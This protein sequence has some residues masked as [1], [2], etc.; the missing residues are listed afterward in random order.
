MRKMGV[1][2]GACLAVAAGAAASTAVAQE[3]NG[4][5]QTFDIQQRFEYG[6]NVDLEV[7]AEGSTTAAATVLSY[8]L[9]SETALDRLAFTATGA[10]VIENSPDTAGTEVEFDRPE[11]GFLYVREIP[12]ALFSIS[13]RYARDDVSELAEDLADA[14]ADGTEID[15]GVT[16]RYEG[17][18]TSPASIF[19]EATFDGTEYEDTTD[20]TL[21]ESDTFGIAVGTRLRLNEVLDGVFSLGAEREE[22]VTGTV[23]NRLVFR[24]GLEYEMIDG[25]AAVFLIREDGDVEDSTGLE[26]DYTR[27]LA[28]GALSFGLS[29]AESDEVGV[30]G[31]TVDTDID[32]GWAQSVNDVSSITLAV[33]WAQSDTPAERI[34]ETELGATYSYALTDRTRLDMGASYRVREDGAGRATSPEVFLALGRSF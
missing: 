24:A 12:D 20:P 14:D 18:R 8:G 9:T 30:A 4:I 26:L 7:P 27:E 21:I 2:R 5:R 11:V 31:T 33:S 6:R 25:F 29:Y 15:Y 3:S 10:L 28:D 34:E 22:E 1:I 32:I 19:V 13:A 16:L 17:M 23:D